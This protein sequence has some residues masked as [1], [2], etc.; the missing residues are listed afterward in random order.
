LELQCGG[1]GA[2]FDLDRSGL[3]EVLYVRG[4]LARGADF[5]WNRPWTAEM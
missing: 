5:G 2:A 4:I 1:A 3:V